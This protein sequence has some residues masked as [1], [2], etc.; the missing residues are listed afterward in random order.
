M[1]ASIAEVKNLVQE[2]GT[3][4][5]QFKRE[6]DEALAQKADRS[7]VDPL[8][9]E[10]VEK[11]NSAITD[12]EEKLE[13][14][15][16][17]VEQVALSA[18][19]SGMGGVSDPE[20]PRLKS[21]FE[22]YRVKALANNKELDE[23]D[24]SA[25]EYAEYRKSLVRYLRKDQQALSADQI[26]AM[27]LGSDP[28]GGYFATPEMSGRIIERV[29]ETSPLRELAF[30]ETISG[31]SLDV[32]VETQEAEA[33]WA[34][35]TESRGNTDGPKVGKK[36]IVAHEMFAQPLATQRLL[37]DAGLDI[38]AWI[39]RRVG[40]KMG[41]LEATAFVKGDGVNKPRGFTTY[42]DGTSFGQVRQVASGLATSLNMDSLLKLEE[43][44]KGDYRARA[45]WGFNRHTAGILRRI[46][47]ASG[48]SAGT[49]QY[50]WQPSLQAGQP[51][52]L[53]GYAVSLMEDMPNVGAGAL[54]VVLGDFQ[55]GYTIV[56]KPGV[57][58]LR[59]PYTSKPFVKFYTVRRVG[60][61]VVDFDAIKLLR[62]AE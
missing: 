58:V 13:N 22:F 19:R 56:D 5:E 62:I 38:E 34:G 44:L 4:F 12:M 30:I 33:G 27:S 61:D 54:A 7:Y 21:A 57:R 46:R 60:G 52:E 28:D 53:L 42:P 24:V 41:R 32:I 6:N 10:K 18:Q 43:E 14:I 31:P 29:H 48:A 26:K 8:V 45:R 25:E 20:D 1:A 23:K 40:E 59:D 37:D 2:L 39:G 50:L 16:K 9:E 47:D 15:N 49:G 36:E 17:E 11:M 3:T 35:E 55:T 51:P